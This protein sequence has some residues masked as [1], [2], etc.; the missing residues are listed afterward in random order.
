MDSNLQTP[1]PKSQ[2]DTIVYNLNL[3]DEE[4]PT[5]KAKKD[6]KKYNTFKHSIYRP[7]MEPKKAVGAIDNNGHPK[8]PVYGLGPVVS[9]GRG[10]DLPSKSTMLIMSKAMVT[11]TL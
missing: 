5:E 6:L 3:Q 7:K 9:G 1:T 11:M 8:V 2:W 10:K 4:S